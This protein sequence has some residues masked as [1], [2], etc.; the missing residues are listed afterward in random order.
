MKFTLTIDCNRA[1][2]DDLDHE[3]ARLLRE[4]ATHIETGIPYGQHPT[5]IRDI[6]GNLVGHFALNKPETGE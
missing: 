2:F 1:A 6:N 3:L 5:V 4:T